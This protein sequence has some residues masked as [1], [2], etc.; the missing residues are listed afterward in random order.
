MN[1]TKTAD[2]KSK[3]GGL[4]RW[5]ESFHPKK[6]YSPA[7]SGG[8]AT[9]VASSLRNIPE[10]LRHGFQAIGTPMANKLIPGLGGAALGGLGGLAASEGKDEEGKLEYKSPLLKVLLGAGAGAGLGVAGA[11]GY[12]RPKPGPLGLG[13]TDR[14]KIGADMK[15]GEDKIAALGKVAA[16]RALSD[17]RD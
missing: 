13:G 17:L 16:Q 11:S 8:W 5:M 3:L 6:S 7:G 4:E 9:N 2:L 1:T 12:V 14:Y 10:G 15:K